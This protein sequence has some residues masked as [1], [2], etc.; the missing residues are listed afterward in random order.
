MTSRLFGKA[1]LFDWSGIESRL[2]FVFPGEGRV[3]FDSVM[4]E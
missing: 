4:R 2:D 3:F 1:A